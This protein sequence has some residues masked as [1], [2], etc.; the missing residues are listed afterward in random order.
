MNP[1]PDNVSGFSST[2]QI[3]NE[4][5]P[6]DTLFK[7]AVQTIDMILFCNIAGRLK[8]AF[9]L[10]QISKHHLCLKLSHSHPLIDEIKPIFPYDLASWLLL[11]PQTPLRQRHAQ[12]LV[13]RPSF[14]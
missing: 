13:I 2:W 14:I 7:F 4:I 6:M 8:G 9:S 5:V 10:A 1:F 11:L 3:L 12:L